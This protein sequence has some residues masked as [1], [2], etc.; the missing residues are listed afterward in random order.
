[1]VE[2]LILA[3][4]YVSTAEKK[5]IKNNNDNVIDKNTWV[6]FVNSNELVVPSRMLD[7]APVRVGRRRGVEDARGRNVGSQLGFQW[8]RFGAAQ[9]ANV[10]RRAVAWH[11][12]PPA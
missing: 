3:S 10:A 8:A 11:R 1:M 4:K 7:L 5:Y 6:T 2:R 12:C 9:I